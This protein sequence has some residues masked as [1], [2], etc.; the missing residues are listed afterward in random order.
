[1][2]KSLTL[3]K[4]LALT[5][6]FSALVI[7][8]TITHLGLISIGSVAS[9]TIL[10]IPVILIALLSGLPEGAFVGTVFGLMSMTM[11]YISPSGI[12]DPMFQNPLCSVLPRIL[13][14]VVAWAIWRLLNF[15]PKMPKTISAGITGFLATIAHTFMVYAC[16]FIFEGS[17]MKEL[18]IQ[19]GLTVSYIG[20]IM[21]GIVGEILEAVA[22]TLVCILVYAGLF[23]AGKR[24]SKLSSMSDD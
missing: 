13:L 17:D 6:A 2:N 7:V 8:L 11:A 4:K 9:I 23:I 20:V 19:N 21:L 10:Q 22:S 16:I 15:I 12:L 24:K 1:M 3:N 18:L 14:G 5:G